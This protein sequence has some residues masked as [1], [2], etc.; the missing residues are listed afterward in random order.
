VTPI[1]GVTMAAATWPAPGAP[2]HNR[3]SVIVVARARLSRSSSPWARVACPVPLGQFVIH[4]HNFKQVE[5]IPLLYLLYR[6]S[7]LGGHQEPPNADAA[8]VPKG[9]RQ[10]AGGFGD[11]KTRD[12]CNHTI[13][14]TLR[15]QH[16]LM[17]H[18]C[19]CQLPLPER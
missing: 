9:L 18:P 13:A 7:R 10:L 17:R 14:R 5:E 8:G 1:D 6:S 4:P 2:S 16:E 19:V 3:T 15:Y 12:S 11:E